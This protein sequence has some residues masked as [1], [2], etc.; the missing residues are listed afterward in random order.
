MT[1][2]HAPSLSPADI[3]ASSI[4]AFPEGLVGCGSWKHF[5]LLTSDEED[6]PV[7]ILQCIDEPSVRFMVTD[8]RLIDATYSAELSFED[9][10]AFGSN[11]VIYCT[12][13]VANDGTITAN[14]LG[15]LVINTQTR[16]AKQV[17]LTDDTYSARHPV[18]R[19]G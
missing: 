2:T 13:T 15:P 19:L 14:L 17:V 18:G 4:I 1:V 12:L 5:V 16:Q 7:G 3:D 6:L 11:P 8:P 9:K 10:L